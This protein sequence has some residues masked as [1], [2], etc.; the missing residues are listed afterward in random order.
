MMSDPSSKAPESV[1]SIES[2]QHPMVTAGRH[3]LLGSFLSGVLVLAYLWLSVDM[4]YG[5]WAA[6]GT[7]RL[8]GAI[9]IPLLC[10]F[11]SASF[12]QRVIRVLSQVVESA[13]LPF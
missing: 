1:E 5:S 7:E 8:A 2:K 9:A 6:V 3:F 10:G 12:G 13:N 4:T 11:L